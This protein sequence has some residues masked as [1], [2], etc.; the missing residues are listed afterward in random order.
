MKKCRTALFAVSIACLMLFAG[1]LISFSMA[2]S[3]APENSWV[4][5]P[6]HVVQPSASIF[7]SGYSPSQIRAAYGLPSG[8][9]AG[10]TIAI[11]DAFDAPTI[12][13]D[14]TVFS[15]HFNLP[16]PT[17]NNFEVRKMVSN[18]ATDSGWAQET[19]L[20]VEWAHAIAPDAKILLVQARSASSNDLLSA[21]DYARGRSDVVAISMSWGDNEFSTEAAYNYHFTSNYGAT[22]FASSGD[23]GSGAM[24]PASS[25][26]VVGVG[27]TTLYLNPDGSV[28]SETA[29][30]GSG[31]GTSNY[32]PRPSFQT[33]FGVASTRRSI[34]DVSY[35]ANPNTGVSVYY[36]SQWQIIGGTSA[37]APQWAAI[38][39]LGRSASNGNFY[40]RAKVNYSGYFRDITSGSNGGYTAGAGYDAVT[41]LGSPLTANFAASSTTEINYVQLVPAGQSTPL[42]GNNMFTVVYQQNGATVTANVQDSTSN[43]ITDTNTNI[44][45]AGISTGSILTEKWVLNS[46]GDPVSGKNLTLYYY[47]TLSQQTSYAITGGGN[48]QKPTVNYFSAPTAASDQQRVTAKNLQLNQST[49][50]FW[51]L[52]GTGVS[53]TNPL[54]ENL[55]EQWSTPNATWLITSAN[56]I[57]TSLNYYHQYNATIN[58]QILG[59]GTPATPNL[60]T[61]TNGS[62]PAIALPPN[63]TNLWLDAGTQYQLPSTLA[64]SSNIERWITNTPNGTVNSPLNITATY[65]HQFNVSAAYAVVGGGNQTAPAFNFSAFGNPSSLQLSGNTQFA[66]I[67]NGTTFAAP[68][69]L[70]G[71]SQT[72]RWF[73]ASSSGTI[74]DAASLNFVYLRQFLLNVTGMQTN[75]QWYNSGESAQIS[76]PSA[77]GREAGN[78]TGQ[79]LTGYTIDNQTPV[80][81][82]PS[83]GTVNLTIAMNAPHLL[84]V[85]SKQ[86]YQVALDDSAAKALA[87]I[88]LPSISGDNYWYD[89]GT[90][91]AIS[92][93]GTVNRLSGAGQRITSYTINGQATNASS[94]GNL[95]IFNGT[96][97]SPQTISATYVNQYLL[98]TPNGSVKSITAPSIAGDAGWYDLGTPVTVTYENIWNA[99]AQSRLNA[100]SYAISQAAPLPLARSGSG[101]FIAQLTLT[102]P[103][104]ITVSSVSQYSLEVSGGTNLVYSQPSPTKDAFYDAGTTLTVTTDRLLASANGNMKQVLSGYTLDGHAVTMTRSEIGAFTTPTITLVAPHQLAFDSVTQYLMSF[105]FKDNSGNQTIT[106]TSLQIRTGNSV[107]DVPTFSAWLDGGTQF[108]I[109]SVTWQGIDVKPATQTTKTVNGPSNQTVLC[110]I[111]NGKLLLQNSQG[112]PLAGAQVKVTLANQTVI[113]AVTGSDGAVDLPM[114]PLGTFNAEATYSGVTVAFSGDASTQAITTRTILPASTPSPVGSPS[115]SASVP[116]LPTF[117]AFFAV[118]AAGSVVALV[119]RRKRRN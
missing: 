3:Q 90:Q 74:H 56:Q 85:D 75:V 66:W 39:A 1:S 16:L 93:N 76:L 67:D 55:M 79:R 50:T 119:A 73:S 2:L 18:L 111:F 68:A 42:S 21:I 109:Q 51:P 46:N 115:P 105:Q 25:P 60:Q 98:S 40:A 54:T 63:G 87:S 80:Q 36:N 88:T 100:V 94:T 23:S 70:S 32:E 78:G 24:W 13:N 48:P 91:V 102:D 58:Y 59:G 118:L 117:A 35:N 81:V 108:Q 19:T 49:Q 89:A 86:Q 62:S 97:I 17:A 20:D 47:D 44:T 34:P 65:Y 4:A 5:R 57:P 112:A 41:G 38:Q 10:T 110:R 28:S 22:F 26:N 37:G 95:S 45:V 92:L 84:Q 14:L 114:I 8:G 71:S 64:P 33:S 83:T 43:F 30:S 82:Q 11:I 9:G 77:T 99:T 96:L 107:L 72:E 29:W 27:G 103:E 7:A 15:S 104:T 31:G 61:T 69:Q 113:N 52:L 101:T 53:V 106:P 6:F 12:Q 116:E